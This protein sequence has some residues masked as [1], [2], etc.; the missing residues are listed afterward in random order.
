M[1]RASN[2][3]SRA[4]TSDASSTTLGSRNTLYLGGKTPGDDDDDFDE[5]SWHSSAQS[6]RHQHRHNGTATSSVEEEEEED[7]DD[8]DSAMRVEDEKKPIFAGISAKRRN[9]NNN[10]NNFNQKKSHGATH[11]VKHTEND[12][13]VSTTPPHSPRKNHRRDA[14]TSLGGGTGGD[15]DDE[16][17][18]SHY[19]E[20][21]ARR[22]VIRQQPYYEFW[23]LVAGAI[24]ADLDDI[25]DPATLSYEVSRHTKQ[26][27]ATA[28]REAQLRVTQKAIDAL[29]KRHE[30]LTQV[31]YM[32]MVEMQDDLHALLEQTGSYKR[33]SR[34]TKFFGLLVLADD[35]L[36]VLAG[37]PVQALQQGNP[38]AKQ[39]RRFLLSVLMR[40]L[41]PAQADV[42]RDLVTR[43]SLLD[44]LN[45]TTFVLVHRLIYDGDQAARPNTSRP[46][47]ATYQAQ[48]LES[49]AAVDDET[50]QY[51]VL[52]QSAYNALPRVSETRAVE[53]ALTQAGKSQDYTRFILDYLAWDG[54]NPLQLQTIVGTRNLLGMHDNELN[55]LLQRADNTGKARQTVIRDY[56]VTLYHSQTG[57]VDQYVAAGGS[58]QAYDKLRVDLYV[59]MK[60]ILSSH[61]GVYDRRIGQ[62]LGQLMARYVSADASTLFGG[63]ADEPSPNAKLGAPTRT[64]MKPDKQ[65]VLSVPVMATTLLRTRPTGEPNDST[66][67]TTPKSERRTSQSTEATTTVTKDISSVL[68]NVNARDLVQDTQFMRYYNEGPASLTSDDDSERQHQL[69]KASLYEVDA[70]IAVETRF[71]GV[72][73]PDLIGHARLAALARLFL[74][75]GDFVSLYMESLVERMAHLER[76]SASIVTRGNRNINALDAEEADDFGARQ[77]A[78]HAKRR[79]ETNASRNSIDGNAVILELRPQVELAISDAY[80]LVQEYCP[81]LKDLPRAAFQDARA[82]QVGLGRDLAQLIGAL[83]AGQSVLYP[84]TYKSRDYPGQVVLRKMDIMSR[85]QYYSYSRV[86]SGDSPG[87]F[88]ITRNAEKPRRP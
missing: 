22:E 71:G 87:A 3:V 52:Q 53:K 79:R 7:Y 38:D 39:Y 77:V 29:E 37:M 68:I 51:R 34:D 12:F 41:D 4:N 19:D 40:N 78:R 59:P 49:G 55:D 21:T 1:A 75:Y 16:S 42:A 31:E 18:A 62:L 64:R 23:R 73:A 66:T 84:D 88:K 46:T 10:S 58:Q 85:L 54:N 26:R 47:L 65:S 17:S 35:Y 14:R 24:S 9:S 8:D 72:K 13:F 86:H 33:N 70:P 82:V 36:R 61:I 76:Q 74:D 69:L 81:A 60:D 27:V 44:I 20:E 5:D 56:Y 45:L 2:T 83:N 28:E 30:Y 48:S 25:F 57:A 43:S 15:D 63:D 11:T 32:R 50:S 6:Q 80:G 67:T